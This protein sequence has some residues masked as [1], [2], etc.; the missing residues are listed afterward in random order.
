MRLCCIQPIRTRAALWVSCSGD[1]ELRWPFCVQLR[2]PARLR[3]PCADQLTTEMLVSTDSCIATPY[4]GRRD[5]QLCHRLR[6]RSR[7]SFKVFKLTT[8]SKRDI[9]FSPDVL[10]WT[11]GHVLPRAAMVSA[12]RQ[13]VGFGLKTRLAENESWQQDSRPA[14]SQDSDDPICCRAQLLSFSA[15][16]AERRAGTRRTK[17]MIT[18]PIILNR[19]M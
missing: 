16:R 17:A 18:N 11:V 9:P 5:R 2:Q 8:A 15:R 19:S 10:V 7:R 1:Q 12:G 3:T 14:W 6:M 13:M 4:H